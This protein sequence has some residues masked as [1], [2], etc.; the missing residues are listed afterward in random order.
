MEH[1]V[2][3]IVRGSMT[4]AEDTIRRIDT[5]VTPVSTKPD[6]NPMSEQPVRRW[7]IKRI[8]TAVFYSVL[9]FGL[10]SYIAITLVSLM[11]SIEVESAVVT[12]PIETIL[13]STSGVIVDVPVDQGALLSTGT[14]MM[15]IQDANLEEA[16][17]R[18][19]I[20]VLGA[21]AM[22][23][24]TQS[25]FDLALGR[26]DDQ[27]VQAEHAVE[28]G[29]IRV[30]DLARRAKVAEDHLARTQLLRDQGHMLQSKVDEA[31]AAAS[32]LQAELEA[33]RADVRLKKE[34]ASRAADGLLVGPEGVD[35]SLFVLNEALRQK[36]LALDR[37]R[38]ALDA[39]TQQRDRISVRA[40]EE[41]RIIRKLKS[42][43]SGVKRGEPVALYERAV[44]QRIEAYLT[45]EEL[46]KI[47]ARSL[48]TVSLPTE[49]RRIE[50][51]IV[52]IDRESAYVDE[53]KSRYIWRDDDTRTIRVTLETEG[54]TI[55]GRPSIPAIVYFRKFGPTERIASWLGFSGTEDS[56]AAADD[57]DDAAIAL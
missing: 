26:L 53:H 14:V 4:S 2:E 29:R 48:A 51:R 56:P 44:A 43:G 10:F 7:P 30:R 55:S 23:E 40:P 15:R 36:E 33:A 13:A 19:R 38:M 31:A 6:K 12:A 57:E 34:L 8:A 35:D 24:E 11:T 50:A 21:E 52:T 45:H 16:I 3:N 22:L 54:L 32:Q 5:P 37:A 41:G 20:K 9:G 25:A 49:N 39:L 28:L 27:L 42:L 17:E 47:D 46:L 18:G 1:F